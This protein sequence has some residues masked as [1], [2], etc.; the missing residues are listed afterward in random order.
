MDKIKTTLGSILIIDIPKK[1]M[2]SP[3]I[4]N[5]YFFIKL[6]IRRP[7]TKSEKV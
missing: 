4:K 3:N 2:N 5:S 1:I 6:T 7:R